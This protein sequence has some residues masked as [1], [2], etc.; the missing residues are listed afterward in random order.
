MFPPIWTILH[1]IGGSLRGA[2]DLLN[3]LQDVMGGK[4]TTSVV[5][6]SLRLLTALALIVVCFSFVT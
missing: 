1:C 4:V 2:L 3:F 5:V 6:I